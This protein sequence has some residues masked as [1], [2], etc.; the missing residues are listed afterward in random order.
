MIASVLK[1][2]CTGTGAEASLGVEVDMLD[3][4]DIAITTESQ[5]SDEACVTTDTAEMAKLERDVLTQQDLWWLW[6]AE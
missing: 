5:T 6:N 2:V 1:G 4:M 3:T